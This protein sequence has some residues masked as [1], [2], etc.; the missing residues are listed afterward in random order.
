MCVVVSTDV[1]RLLYVMRF[2]RLSVMLRYG[3]LKELSVTQM[4][5]LMQTNEGVVSECDSQIMK[6]I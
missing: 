1:W 6:V 3:D 5:M 4:L 2:R